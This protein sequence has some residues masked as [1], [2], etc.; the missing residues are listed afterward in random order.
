MRFAAILAV[1]GALMLAGCLDASGSSSAR[2]TL[3]AAPPEKRDAPCLVFVVVDEERLPIQNASVTLDELNLVVPTDEAGQVEICDIPNGSYHIA[4]AAKGYDT[5]RKTVP[6][7]SSAPVQFSLRLLPVLVPYSE[8]LPKSLFFTVSLSTVDATISRYASLDQI[9]C[10][11][12]TLDFVT[13]SM[14]DFVYWEATWQ[15][16]VTILPSED[17][18]YHVF[19]GGS[20][21]ENAPGD[22]TDR[23][24]GVGAMAQPFHFQYHRND[25]VNSPPIAQARDAGGEVA[26]SG[27]MY[28]WGNPP[29]PCVNQ[30][31]DVYLTVWYNILKVPDDYSALPPP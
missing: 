27:A 6:F 14:P 11:P 7:P 16:S 29:A 15:R 28:C 5:A 23:D 25:M 26:F 19:R 13:P 1:L 10:S 12:C 4:V 20:P 8:I 18:M 9:A 22:T 24:I 3:S 21:F 2:P 17:Q 30:R 31:I